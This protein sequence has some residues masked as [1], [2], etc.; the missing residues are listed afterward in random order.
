MKTRHTSKHTST[1]TQNTNDFSNLGECHDSGDLNQRAEQIDLICRRRL[2]DRVFSGVLGGR[3]DEIRQDALIMLLQGFLDGSPQ[4]M[5][6]SAKNDRA[7]TTYHQER[8]VALALR[9]SERRMIRK[10]AGE[11]MGRVQLNEQNGGIRLQ[12]WEKQLWELPTATR[13]E[14]AMIALQLAVSMNRLSSANARITAMVIEGGMSVEEV[15]KKRKVKRGSIYRH[16][17]RVLK[18]L[19]GL[20]DKVEVPTL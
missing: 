2:R 5:E 14:M 16:L 9:Y 12:I 17:N 6:A 3:S 15:A 13:V 7:A 4:F 10:L 19:P 8:V 11:T 20:M 1:G 18:V